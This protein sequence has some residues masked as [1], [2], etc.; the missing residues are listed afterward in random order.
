MQLTSSIYTPQNN[1]FQYFL[2]MLGQM[3]HADLVRQNE[4]L[5]VENKILRSK[6]GKKVRTTQQEKL[7]LIK[8]GLPVGGSIK[9]LI[10]IVTYQT[11]RKWVNALEDGN[12]KKNV[13]LGRPRR[14]SQ[15][16]VDIILRMARENL[17]W[18]YGRIMGELKKLGIKRSRNTIKRIMIEHGINPA[19]KR[20]EDSW[21]AYLKRTFETLW[22]CDFFSQEIWT[23]LG[24]K[25]I[26]VLF[27]INIRTRQVHIAGITDHPK[28]LWMVN[29]AKYMEQFFE[30]DTKKILIR[31]GDKKFTA[32]FDNIFKIHNTEVKQI[33]YKSPN[34]NPYSEAFV[35][36][37]SRE[38]LNKFF[39]FGQTH[40]EYLIKNF[41]S[42]YN[43]QR[44]HSG[45]DNETIEHVPVGDGNIK[46]KSM[47]GGVV[48]HYY[49]E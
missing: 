40:F 21:D 6:L 38:C 18:G 31:D 26:F 48:K 20:Y 23:P 13:R 37:I 29:R 30:D 1:I 19:P 5:K 17:D 24:K 8:Y 49:R 44:P 41:V 4:Y 33:P 22:G 45:L 47:V 11:F 12:L 27:F 10:S 2:T 36:I 9:K 7:K 42:Y 14:T 35:S 15:E 3:V 16:I 34:L 46:C 39:I 28:E 25:V 32:K 43:Q